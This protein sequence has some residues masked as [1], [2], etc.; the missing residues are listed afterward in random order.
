MSAL[1]QNRTILT[2]QE[3]LELERTADFK[4]EYVNG[5]ATAMAGASSNHDAICANLGMILGSQLRSRPCRIFTSD[6]K[7][8]IDKANAFRYPD[9]SGLYGPV[10]Y[11]DS[12]RDAYCNPAVIFEVLSPSTEAFDRGEKFRLY[13]LLDSLFEYILVR[14]DRVEV[15]VWTRGNEGVWT[16]IIYNERTDSFPLRTLD[17]TLKLADFY[18]K[19]EFPA[20]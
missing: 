8:R 16:S 2:A 17:C 12:T 13:R 14:Q 19:V 7:V 15:E 1:K 20:E 10:L 3:Y 5:D 11:H 6:F 18:E 4:S 9:V